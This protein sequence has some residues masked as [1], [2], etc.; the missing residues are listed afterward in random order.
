MTTIA[1]DGRF[2]AADTRRTHRGPG[3]FDLFT[4]D[5]CKL[6]IPEEPCFFNG[7]LVKALAVCGSELI[8]FYITELLLSKRDVIGVLK[9][10]ND[11]YQKEVAT[12]TVLTEN[13]LFNLYA[14]GDCSEIRNIP[15]G[16]GTGGLHVRAII[17]S[18][19]NAMRA[20]QDASK[21]CKY[22]NDIVD[23]IDTFEDK[24]IIRRY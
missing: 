21:V 18:T 23:F 4:D 22:T 19:V 16:I 15:Y 1:F 10:S 6:T 5:V 3:S 14:N 9:H 24:L 8:S 20:V 13:K 2:L 17:S 7:E 11:V 12:V